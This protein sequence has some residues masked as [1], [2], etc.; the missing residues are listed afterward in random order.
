ME[1]ESSCCAGPARLTLSD[2]IE[3]GLR[4]RRRPPLGVVGAWCEDASGRA[5]R[6]SLC[7]EYDVIVD[8]TFEASSCVTLIAYC[9]VAAE[10]IRD[11]RIGESTR[12]VRLDDLVSALPSVPV[13]RCDAA[14]LAVQA[15]LLALGSCELEKS[16]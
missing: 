10:L 2:Y 1:L 13:A 4:R 7:V 12:R 6:F 14:L 11:S 16:A 9:E 5:V 8:V 15:L 3:R